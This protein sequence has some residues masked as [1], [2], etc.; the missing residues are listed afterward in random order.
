MYTLNKTAEAILCGNLAEARE[1][2]SNG[3]M[4]SGQFVENNKGQLFSS[5]LNYKAFDLVESFIKAGLIQ[6]DIYE[7]DSFD[8]SFFSSIAREL[9]NDEESI[10]FLQGFLQKIDSKND[11]VKDQTLLGYCLDN[12]ALPVVIKCLVNAGC[13]AR[14]KNNAERNFAHQVVSKNMLPE[15]KGIAYLEILLGEGV[16][17]NDKD[18][19]GQTPLM[20]AV[21]GRKSEIT[22]WLLQNGAD[23]NE[24]DKNGNTAFYIAAVEQFDEEMLKK[25][26]EYGTPDFD[27]RNREEATLMGDFMRMMQGSQSDIRLLDILLQ[28]GA[29]LTQT[30]PYYMEPKSG[31]D[32]LTEKGSDVLQFVLSNNNLDLNA[33]DNFGNTLLHKICAYNVNFDAEIARDLYK[34]VKLLLEA[35]ADVSITNDNDETPLM[36]AQKDNLKIK[37]VELLMSRR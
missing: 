32:W 10:S 13:N 36:L 17:I 27:L 5:I 31:I 2:L 21:K 33:Q 14:Y 15:E 24:Q 12:G 9:K 16:D 28:A 22:S 25:L 4:L 1:K 34:K 6:T 3:E 37:T 29:D 7:Y 26:C 8:Q 19:S 30:S 11:E 23:P 35:G 20:V 18:I